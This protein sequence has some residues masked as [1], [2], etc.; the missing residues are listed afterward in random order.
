M[1]PGSK[2]QITLQQEKEI[3]VIVA[4][5]TREWE[6]VEYA[7]DAASIGKNK[8]IILTVHLISE[9]AGI[10][11]CAEWIKTFIKDVPIHYISAEDPFWSSEN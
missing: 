10:E 9:E 2:R 6:T 5:E 4:G 7:R 8:A 3:E 1:T 11:Y